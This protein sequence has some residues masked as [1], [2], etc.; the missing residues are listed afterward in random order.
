[1]SKRLNERQVAAIEYL[2]QPKRSGMTYGEIAE[3]VGVSERQLYTW[4]QDDVFADA[5]IKRTIQKSAEHLPEILESIPKHIIE[6]GNAAMFRTFM[7]SIG[8]LT[9]KVEIGTKSNTDADVDKMREEIEKM[10]RK[11][12][13]G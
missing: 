7:Q 5:V 12:S 6:E 8:A 11:D 2:S 4:R 9:E 1:M 3:A 13:E 10:R